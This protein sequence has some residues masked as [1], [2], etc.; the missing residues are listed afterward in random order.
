[1]DHGVGVAGVEEV[2]QPILLGIWGTE[3]P[4]LVSGYNKMD[5]GFQSQTWVLRGKKNTF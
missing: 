2:V 1:M 4:Q 3:K 5:P